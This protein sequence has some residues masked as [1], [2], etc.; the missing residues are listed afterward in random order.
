MRYPDVFLLVAGVALPAALGAQQPRAVLPEAELAR[1]VAATVDSLA[2]RDE[3][4]GV[5]ALVRG[6]DT[7][8]LRAVGLADRERGRRNDIA[9]AFNIG[10]I[11]KAFTAIAVRQLAEAGKLHLDS[12]LGAYWPDYPNAGARSATIRQILSHRSGIAGDIFAAPPGRSRHDLRHNT[13]LLPLIVQVPLDFPPGTGQRYSNAGYVVLGALIERLSGEDY[14]GYVS[15]HVLAPA[16]MIHT[17]HFAVDSLP[18]NTALGYTRGVKGAGVLTPNR[19]LL[20]GRGSAAGG[21]YSTA[22]DL[23]R[24]LA[25]L[26]ERRIPGGMP[27]GIGVAGGAPGLN[28]VVEGQLPGGY[29]L[30][31]LANLDPPAAERIAAR[32]R[33]W[34]GVKDD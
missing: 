4:S 15:R 30:A 10:S 17:G 25:A 28:A 27:A 23:L 14:Y 13:D 11:N 29:D 5:V 8:L 26:R 12:T 7:V 1:R 18:A 9:T 24:F 21:G 3:F 32:V 31:V 33:E 20:P 2:A 16:G 6:R 34:L 19:D 22:G